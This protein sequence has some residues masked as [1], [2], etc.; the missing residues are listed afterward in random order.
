MIDFYF[1]FISPYGYL[2]ALQIDE[3]AARYERRVEWHPMLLGVSV[4]KAM[5][6]KP[7]LETPLKG[8]YVL[9]DVPRL[10]SFYDI[11]LVIS[12]SGL[13][14]PLP[15]ARAFCW[16]KSMA[17]ERAADYARA[18]YSAQWR[19]GQDISRPALLAE[20][21]QSMGF[22]G[23]ALLEALDGEELRRQ[24]RAEVEDSLALGVFGSPTFI[25]DG[26]MIWGSDRLWML[27]HWLAKGS[28]EPAG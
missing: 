25:V 13:P 12:D 20:L 4:I 22:D 14:Q 10:A 5:G 1:D 24:L 11:P 9:K 3:L 8:D 6:L 28:W 2:A 7:L 17:P 26:E 16:F 19:D 15:S 23:R 21:A 27:E 18:V